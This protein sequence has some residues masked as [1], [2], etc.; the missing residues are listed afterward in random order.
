MLQVEPA[1]N[2]Y[3]SVFNILQLV[4]K[5]IQQL[6]V[7]AASSLTQT[8]MHPSSS[9]WIVRFQ[10][11][12]LHASI[13]AFDRVHVMS[14]HPSTLRFSKVLSRTITDST[15]ING[16]AI[17]DIYHAWARDVGGH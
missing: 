2:F 1:I 6:T 12:R 5:T 15:H 13:S 7:E 3:S 16:A 4:P 10:A 11:R 9:N 8:L 14:S 17:T